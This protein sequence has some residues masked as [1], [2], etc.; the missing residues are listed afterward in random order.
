[1][2]SVQSMLADLTRQERKI[3]NAKRSLR[4]LLKAGSKPEKKAPV[5]RVKRARRHTKRASTPAASA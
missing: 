3:K 1:M 2:E 5:T 4:A